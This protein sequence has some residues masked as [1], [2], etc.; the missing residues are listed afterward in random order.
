MRPPFAGRRL[1]LCTRRRLAGV[2]G[3][4]P[5]DPGGPRR[6]RPCAQATIMAE[7]PRTESLAA[8]RAE[9]DEID[10]TMHGLLMQAA[11]SSIA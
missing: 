6:G 2:A 8:L 5:I 4:E 11:K 3:R 7:K 10:E 1:S 9:I